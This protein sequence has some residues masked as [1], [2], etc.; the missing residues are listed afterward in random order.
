MT[1]KS[2]VS[3]RFNTSMYNGVSFE[4]NLDNGLSLS[5]CVKE[6]YY[7]TRSEWLELAD[8]VSN[9][10]NGSFMI[11][12]TEYKDADSCNEFCVDVTIPVAAYGA[13]Y[14]RCLREVADHPECCGKETEI[15]S[16]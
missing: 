5:Y 15:F 13:D 11:S 12:V 14:A 16:Q 2:K 6:P 7:R 8:S 4:F 1:E 3:V 9:V 10:A